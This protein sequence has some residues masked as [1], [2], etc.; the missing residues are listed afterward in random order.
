MDA[1]I[2]LELSE[3]KGTQ[4]VLGSIIGVLMMTHPNRKLV[5]EALRIGAGKDL[6]A[7]AE[8][9]KH[10]PVFIEA[11]RE[12]YSFY[13]E[14]AESQTPDHAV[15]EKTNELLKTF[16]KPKPDDAED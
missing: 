8:R 10:D 13:L 5:A 6:N 7:H 15:V 11:M 3:I 12:T 4:A 16:S 9:M 14:A 1:D 2:R